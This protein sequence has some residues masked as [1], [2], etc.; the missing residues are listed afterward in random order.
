MQ[1]Q[2]YDTFGQY[3]MEYVLNGLLHDMLNICNYRFVCE[4]IFVQVNPTQ[5]FSKI[6]KLH[7]PNVVIILVSS[8]F[9]SHQQNN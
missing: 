2:I 8:Q 5:T 7:F 4:I 3:T 6:A 1:Y 9:I